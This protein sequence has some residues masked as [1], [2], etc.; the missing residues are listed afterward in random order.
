MVSSTRPAE[1]HLSTRRRGPPFRQ[2]AAANGRMGLGLLADS[3]RRPTCRSTLHQG[4]CRG[5]ATAPDCSGEVDM[6]RSRLLGRVVG[7]ATSLVALVA[8]VGAG[9]KW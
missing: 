8:V 5:H 7:S 6:S 1:P 4:G 9:W 3:S 2:L